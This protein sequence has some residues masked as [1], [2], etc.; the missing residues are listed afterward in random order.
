[1]RRFSTI[2]LCVALIGTAT[3]T[4]D[5]NI[6]GGAWT[7]TQVLNQPLKE[8]FGYGI[9]IHY[10]HVNPAEDPGPFSEADYAQASSLG[11]V[12]EVILTL[13]V[14][15]L[16]A[17]EH[18]D[19]KVEPVGGALTYIGTVTGDGTA[20]FDLIDA[21]GPGGGLDGLPV[22]VRL[23]GSCFGFAVLESSSLYVEISDPPESPPVPA[24]GA[25]LLAAR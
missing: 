25:A 8:F 19:V 1:M 18:V 4:V 10:S 2:G 6:V 7:D 23:D 22:N 9:P 11:L 21:F 12:D 24:P 17:N 3:A 5:A 16:N 15:G 20:S 14:S 13:A